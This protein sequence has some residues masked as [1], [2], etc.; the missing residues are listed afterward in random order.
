MDQY[1]SS[2]FRR[3]SHEV[4]ICFLRL[5]GTTVR[6][7]VKQKLISHYKIIAQNIKI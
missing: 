4:Q 1:M 5:G 3:F 2:Y 6:V 7:Q